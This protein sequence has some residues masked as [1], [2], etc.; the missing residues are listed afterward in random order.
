MTKLRVYTKT[1][2][3]KQLSAFLNKQNVNLKLFSILDTKREKDYVT[4]IYDGNYFDLGV[5]YAYSRRILP[6][7]LNVPKLGFVNFHAAPLPE[8]KG[9]DPYSKGVAD[10]VKEWGVTVHYMNEEYDEGEIID[11]VMFR[12]DRIPKSRQEIGE[13]AYPKLYELF[14]KTIPKLIRDEKSIKKI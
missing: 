10:Q 13:Q 9:G 8:Y 1:R 5:S 3:F 7:L 11:K 4:S 12:L 14:K 2:H 6:P